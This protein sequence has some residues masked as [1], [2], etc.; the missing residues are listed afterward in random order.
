MGLD[1][2]LYA[3]RH[4]ENHESTPAQ[5]RAMFRDVLT[6]T[7][8]KPFTQADSIHFITLKLHMADWKNAFHINQWF[9][10]RL[11]GIE[12]A[13]PELEIERAK[14]QELLELCRNLLKNHDREEASELLPVPQ[15]LFTGL[16]A[17]SE[18]D[19]YWRECYWHD[20]ERTVEQLDVL[21]GDPDL[22]A[23]KF[24]YHMH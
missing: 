16:S 23:W 8:V 6:T 17:A 20:V 12:Y 9:E 11:P 19:R 2:D 18:T 4:L 3:V 10:E 24:Y 7:G 22:T 15:G 1:M 5:E 13:G 21:L 14:L